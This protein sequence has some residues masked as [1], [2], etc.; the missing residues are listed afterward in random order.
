MRVRLR[1]RL[2]K[3]LLDISD[4]ILTFVEVNIQ[5]GLLTIAQN[6]CLSFIGTGKSHMF[7]ETVVT[8]VI[9]IEIRTAGALLLPIL[10][11]GSQKFQGLGIGYIA[12]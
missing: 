11:Y 5:L 1:C 2:K 4:D 3:L 8:G 10:L 12:I 6:V 7:I 9:R